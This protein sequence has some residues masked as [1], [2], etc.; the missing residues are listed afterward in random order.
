MT[1]SERIEFA[2]WDSSILW[3]NH[4]HGIRG[5]LP[6][7]ASEEVLYQP[8]LIAVLAQVSE[9]ETLP[10]GI[11]GRLYEFQGCLVR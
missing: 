1:V 9:K 5:T 11:G 8:C 7:E 6:Q 3:V 2:R 10:L 4:R